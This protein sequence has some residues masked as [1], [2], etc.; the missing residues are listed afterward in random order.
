M[1]RTIKYVVLYTLLLFVLTG[2]RSQQNMQA[3]IKPKDKAPESLKKLSTGIDDL[4]STL[5]N[6][7]KLS[8][9]IPLPQQEEQKLQEQM[10]QE[11]APSQGGQGQQGQGQQGQDQQGQGK[12]SGGASQ[13]GGG[14][15]QGQ[16]QGSGGQQQQ[17]KPTKPSKEEKLKELWDSMQR[18]LEEIHP[19]W[20]AFE[21]EGFKKGATKENGDK[22]EDSFNKM[23]RAIEAKKIVEIYDNASN[24]LLNLKP[25]YDLYLDEIGGDV[26]ALKYAAYQGYVRAI[27]GNTEGATKVLNNIEEN[28]NKLRLKMT[29][30]DKKQSIEKAS[31]SLSDLKDSLSE[32]SRGLFLIKKDII[33]KNLKALEE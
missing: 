23:T 11:Q 17:Q 2:C 6:I 15:S 10:K 26:S 29:E 16:G 31:L 18:K 19:Q 9:D 4:L 20:N 13:G 22:F 8:L 12:G 27:Q 33:I 7:E 24:S 32:N 5:S 1:K 28:V 14:S 25:F 21:V 30:E 3:E